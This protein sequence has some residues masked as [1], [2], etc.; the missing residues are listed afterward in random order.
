M[1]QEALDAHLFSLLCMRRD[2]PGPPRVVVAGT[3]P[4]GVEADHR[5]RGAA[6]DAGHRRNVNEQ[7]GRQ[8]LRPGAGPRVDADDDAGDDVGPRSQRKSLLVFREPG[9]HFDSEWLADLAAHG[10][11]EGPTMASLLQRL[12]KGDPTSTYLRRVIRACGEQSIGPGRAGPGQRPNSQG[13]LD[14]LSERELEVLRLLATELNG[15]QLARHLS[16]SLN[17]LRTHTK[18]IYAKLGV[19]SRRAAVRR[20]AE[21][22]LLPGNRAG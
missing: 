5:P 3:P 15:P 17:T 10:L 18:N 14:P 12:A 2:W 22:D 7:E 19:S 11:A 8:S 16:V 9:R 6:R 1:S 4:A 21:L 20:A 13:L